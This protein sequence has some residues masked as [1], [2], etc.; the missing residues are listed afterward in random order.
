MPETI[1][2][3]AEERMEKAVEALKNELSKIRTGRASAKLLEHIS[4][5]YYGAP[6][7]IPQMASISV[8]EARMLVIKPYDRSMLKEV[9]KAILASNLGITPTNDGQVV[10]I[11]FPPLTEERRKELAKLVSK[12]GEDAKVAVRN[13]R[14]DANE[15]LKKLEKDKVI[16][17]DDLKGYMEDVQKLTDEYI[18]K[19]EKVV[20]EKEQDILTI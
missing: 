14:R 1:L 10:R 9:E 16:S 2:L 15:Q 4:V 6:T 20:K 8:P 7:P 13:V 19:I 11:V 18:E 5:D 17:E 3:D 12:H